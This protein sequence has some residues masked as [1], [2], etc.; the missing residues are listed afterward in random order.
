MTHQSTLFDVHFLPFSLKPFCISVPFQSHGCVFSIQTDKYAAAIR[1][2]FIRLGEPV[3]G[4]DAFTK[5]SITKSASSEHSKY[6]KWL[7]SLVW[8]LISILSFVVV[9]L[10]AGVGGSSAGP[11]FYFGF[12]S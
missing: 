1:C 5:I 11:R 6:A 9:I 10:L 4:V 12:Q 8:V 7:L 3:G 2:S